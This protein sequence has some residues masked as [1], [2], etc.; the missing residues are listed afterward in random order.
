MKK[1]ICRAREVLAAVNHQEVLNGVSFNWFQGE[2]LGILGVSEYGKKAIL[3][4]VEGRLKPEQGTFLMEEQYNIAGFPN[5]SISRIEIGSSLIEQMTVAENMLALSSEKLGFL[6]HYKAQRQEVEADLKGY[7]PDIELDQLAGE[8]SLLQRCRVEIVKAWRDKKRIFL[9]D[10]LDCESSAKEYEQLQKLMDLMKSKGCSF[11]VSSGHLMPLQICADRIAFFKSKHIIKIIENL[12]E[13]ALDM[14]RMLSVYRSGKNP[15]KYISKQALGA[16]FCRLTLDI[17][18]GETLEIDLHEGEIAAVID[19][20]N[21]VQNHIDG[22]C[23]RK[24][25]YSV[26]FVNKKSSGEIRKQNHRV[27]VTS[28]DLR[29]CL[30][31]TF[32]CVENICLGLYNRVSYFG[33]IKKRRMNFIK[34]EFE[35]WYGSSYLS[36][37]NNC[38]QIS[39]RDKVAILLFRQSMINASLV[40]C[41]IPERDMDITLRAMIYEE[42]GR[43]A[44]KGKSICVWTPNNELPED[45]ADRYYVLKN[46]CIYYDVPYSQ[47]GSI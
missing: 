46:E 42:L 12:P 10:N 32:S 17:L 18:K 40:L 30:I 31:D 45:F 22:F 43:L 20:S 41:A 36:S 35:E 27:S 15:E 24:N 1:E 28:F 4:L 38:L 19:F 29:D 9:I 3:D 39:N 44:Q 33:F 47:I 8:L 6:R 14:N 37:Q 16:M 26:C 7:L 5:A 13:N 23:N 34:N 11:L 21:E 25:S 2:T